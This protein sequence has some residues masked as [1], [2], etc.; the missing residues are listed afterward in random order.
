[1]IARTRTIDVDG[2]AFLVPSDPPER[3]AH[4]EACARAVLGGEYSYPRR[5]VENVR[6]LVDVGT[7]LGAFL[8]WA[9]RW[10]PSL[11]RLYGYDPNREALLFAD[12]NVVSDHPR[13]FVLRHAAVTEDPA[14]VFREQIDWGASRTHGERDGVA[15]PALHPRDLPAA[16]V[17]KVDAEGVG[18]EVFRCYRH[19]PGVR[20]AMYESHH[21]EERDVM[22]KACMDAGLVMARGNPHD[23][24]WDVRTWTRPA[25]AV[26]SDVRAYP[27]A[28]CAR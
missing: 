6:S 25:T 11:E 4:S 14:P 17:L 7:N 8:V 5:C 21:D 2:R 13:T 10:W 16:D 15:V 9:I 12:M 28:P 22:A 3:S 24:T 20:V 27:G 26:V 23:P 19:W 18:A 1:M